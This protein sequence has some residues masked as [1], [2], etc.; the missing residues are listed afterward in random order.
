M[1]GGLFFVVYRQA[2]ADVGRLEDGLNFRDEGGLLLDGVEQRQT[3]S[4]EHEF[5]TTNTK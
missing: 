5:V 4:G 3:S 2:L 1:I